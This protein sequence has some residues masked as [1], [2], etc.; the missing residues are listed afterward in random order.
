MFLKEVFQKDHFEKKSAD[1]NKSMKNYP[2]CKELHA[3]AQLSGGAGYLI[4]CLSFLLHP[5]TPYVRAV[6]GMVIKTLRARTC[7]DPE[8]FVSGGPT[9]TFFLVCSGEEEP[10]YHY[11]KGPP[12]ACQR[13]PLKW[14]NIECW[15]GFSGDPDKYC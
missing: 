15:L 13:T 11:Y 9:L 8:S 1:N 14:P 2:V 5:L 6:N 3:H 7:A 12:S 10:E 4:F